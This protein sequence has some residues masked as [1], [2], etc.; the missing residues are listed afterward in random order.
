MNEWLLERL[1]MD[2]DSP[3]YEWELKMHCGY[4]EQM[5]AEGLLIRDPAAERSEYCFNRRGRRLDLARQDGHIFGTD[6]EDPYR[7]IIMVDPADLVQYR[8][9]WEPWLQAVRANNGLRGST[10]WIGKRCIF[11]GERSDEDRRL[12]F[13]LALFRS[14]DQALTHIFSLLARMPRKCRSIVVTTLTF[15]GLPES[16]V[17][18]L[19]R[20]GI[21]WA[22]GLDSETLGIGFDLGHQEA[23][24]ERRW[25][26]LPHDVEEEYQRY[27]FKCR[28]PVHIAGDTGKSGNNLVLVGD[29]QVTISDVPFVLFLRLAVGLYKNKWGV[30]SKSE[31]GGDGHAG[32]DTE[33]QAVHRLRRCFIGALGGLDPQDFIE[34]PRPKT[35]RLSV[36]PSLVSYDKGRL[37]A[38]DNALVRGLAEQLPELA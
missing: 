28:L 20:L 31:I 22:P 27:R 36:H 33:Y 29:S 17:A 4:S 18:N 37:L 5:R 13:V 3:F 35:L 1:E 30:V 6:V 23:D 2:P 8:F 9:N 24:K 25:P 14:T 32:E 15:D 10:S 12:A 38:H 7:P 11:L 19:E 16:D 26:A 34:V 21:C